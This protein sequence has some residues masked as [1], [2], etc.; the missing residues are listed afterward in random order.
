VIPFRVLESLPG[1][2]QAIWPLPMYAIRGANPGN[3]AFSIDGVARASTVPFRLGPSVIHPFFSRRD[4]VLSRR[5]I[6]SNTAATSRA[7]GRA[8]PAAPATDRLHV[9]A[10][11]RL[12]DAGGIVATPF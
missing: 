3:T 6:P 4:A 8:P 5:P 2:V 7:S 12:F 9:S 10:D 1:V 11:V